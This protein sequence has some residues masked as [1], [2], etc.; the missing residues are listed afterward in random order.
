MAANL[1]FAVDDRHW[2]KIYKELQYLDK[3]SVHTGFPSGMTSG[4]VL[5]KAVSNEFGAYPVILDIDRKVTGHT[6]K[7]PNQRVPSR[8]FMRATADNTRNQLAL[9]KMGSK[10]LHKIYS[11]TGTG[12]QALGL[13]GE[14]FVGKIKATIGMSS[15]YAENAEITKALK[16]SS[17]PLIDTSEMRNSVTHK[18]VRDR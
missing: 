18:T 1:Q 7:N 14:W 12:Q 13:L 3:H 2:N 11:N 6:P 15:L 16:G 9:Q 8:P 5:F 4:D 10:L 17:K